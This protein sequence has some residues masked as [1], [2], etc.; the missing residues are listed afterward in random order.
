MAAKNYRVKHHLGSLEC[1]EKCFVILYAQ[2][3]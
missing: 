1:E 3:P 2:S